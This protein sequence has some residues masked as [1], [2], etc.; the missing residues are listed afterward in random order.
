MWLPATVNPCHYLKITPPLR[1]SPIRKADWVG[2][3]SRKLVPGPERGVGIHYFLSALLLL[4]LLAGFTPEA[5]AQTPPL[6]HI[7]L[8]AVNNSIWEG[9]NAIFTITATPAP[10]AALDVWVNLHQTTGNHA[11]D[12][13]NLGEKTV[14][15][16]PLPAGST[17]TSS[18]VTLTIPTINDNTDEGLTHV[19]MNVRERS[20]H[21]THQPGIQSIV[22]SDNDNPAVSFGASTYRVTEGH[23]VSV[24]LNLV[25]PQ[26]TNT[27]VTLTC[28][29]TATS[30]SDY[31]ACPAPVSIP[32]NMGT[33]TFTLSTT[34]DTLQELAETFTLT[35]SSITPSGIDIGGPS[36][37]TITIDDN[38][39]PV[40][41]LSHGTMPVNPRHGDPA[42]RLE[43]SADTLAVFIVTATPP[44][45]VARDARI[46][47]ESAQDHTPNTGTHTLSFTASG[48]GAGEQRY[49]APVRSDI[50]DRLDGEIRATLLPSEN[51]TYTL[52]ASTIH[53]DIVDNDPTKVTLS[54]T[55]TTADED[56][57]TDTAKINLSLSR[58]LVS[59]ERLDIPLQF[60]GGALGDD[61]TLAKMEGTPADISL[62]GSTVTFTGPSTGA[63]AMSATLIVTAAQDTDTEDETVT[64]SIPARA[65]TNPNDIRLRTTGFHC[66]TTNC[67]ATGTG[68][69][70]FTLSD[71]GSRV[72]VLRITPGSA[73][74]EGANATFTITADPAPAGNLTVYLLVESLGGNQV[75]SSRLGEKTAIIPSSGTLT[76]TI[77]TLADSTDE[78]DSDLFVEILAED[79]DGENPGYT[80]HA[81]DYEAELHIQDDDATTVVLTTPDASATKGSST[82][83]ARIVLTLNRSVDRIEQLDVPLVFT[84]G[85]RV[86]GNPPTGDF[87]LALTPPP[88]SLASS[89]TLSTTSN[90]VSF[91]ALSP[92][93]AT[94]L[95]TAVADSDTIDKTVTVSL[96]AL[97]IVRGFAGGV[98]GS[99]SGDGQITLMDASTTQTPATPE[100]TITP[101]TSP[102]IE[103]TAATFTVTATPP[104]AAALTVNLTITDAP[105][106][107]FVSAS[108]QQGTKTVTIQP[109]STT[110]SSVTYSVPTETD[111]TDEPNGPVMVTIASGSGYTIGS[112][113]SAS[114]TVNDD[115]ATPQT[116]PVDPPQQPVGP[117]PVQPTPTQPVS[118]TSP[119]QPTDPQQP[120]PEPEPEPVIPVLSIQAQADTLTEGATA[121]FT[122]T[123][124]PAPLEPISV[125]LTIAAQGDFT[126]AQSTGVKTLTIDRATTSLMI[127][128]VS[129][130][131]DEADGSIT[132]TLQPADGYTLSPN[133]AATVDIHDDDTA[134]FQLS[135]PGIRIAEIGQSTQYTIQLTSQPAA[136]V[137]ITPITRPDTGTVTPSPTRVTFTRDNWNLAQTFTLTAQQEGAVTLVHVITSQDPNY[138]TLPSRQ[139]PL[140][141]VVGEDLT[142]ITASWQSRFMRTSAGHVVESITQRMQATPTTGLQ[143]QLAGYRMDT[144]PKEMQSHWMQNSRS[145]AE[146]SRAVTLSELLSDSSMSWTTTTDGSIASLWAQGALSEFNGQ[147]GETTLNGEVL[148][149]LIGMDQTHTHGQRGL[150]LSYSQAEGQYQTK[151]QGEIES[152]QTLLTPWMS[153]Q[154]NDRMTLWGALGYGTGDLTLQRSERED[155]TTDTHTAFVAIGSD[156]V[157][158]EETDRTLSIV[159]DALWL[160]TRSDEVAQGMDLGVTSA[161]V[162]TMRAGME[163]RWRPTL[164][165]FA[166]FRGHHLELQAQ[167][168]LRHDGGDAESGFGVEVGGGVQ[169]TN[170][171]QGLNLQINGR[172][173]IT[174]HDSDIKDR[175]LSLSMGFNPSPINQGFTFTLK[176]DWGTVSSGR[177]RLLTAESLEQTESATEQRFKAQ[178]GYGFTI[179]DGRYIAR[180][181]LGV[182]LY[183][184]ERE[185]TLGWRLQS[186]IGRSE[187]TLGLKLTR[188]E[189]DDQSEHRMKVEA[190]VRW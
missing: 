35:I 64:V 44:F 19:Q 60:S 53:Y 57:S 28:T 71:A 55:D 159:T 166:R 135:A 20:T 93:T 81:E 113:G 86:S 161:H 41:T 108:N 16:P 9:A 75:A 107:D 24:T 79:T 138:A 87:T 116:D 119:G 37:T 131:I 167:S 1:G 152:E 177:E 90:V 132:V 88:G 23:S 92:N 70:M 96:G 127:P 169:W 153:R 14:T 154:V 147:S 49:T 74:T 104:P 34:E 11:V 30:G 83:T 56:D 109:A 43:E 122:V 136:A 21:Y 62:S 164:A 187:R 59:G 12:P 68:S 158:Q 112:S 180:P 182:G 65:G 162:S 190:G 8:G 103:G 128:T 47:I 18:S 66:R 77:P 98:T 126:A 69:G 51:N 48:D 72:P 163:G 97:N 25:R 171:R 137:T 26:S 73:I 139:A 188:H 173:L 117:T 80:L 134:G 78:P 185:T 148:T 52:G 67:K 85:S 130:F 40:L 156:S 120:E 110:S 82:D 149:T 32:A 146:A 5:T 63:T 4:P 102:V 42:H 31:A 142:A 175:G 2:G 123:A 150:V 7:T 170:P 45:T 106:S 22:V 118:P 133:P 33:H 58:G 105:N 46:R 179:G 186:V 178:A 155:L 36:S 124:E 183:A 165:R 140:R 174:H 115:D 17:D 50:T 89:Q 151:N 39:Q 10:T 157:L 121:S 76:Y 91:R 111:T 144:T 3:F 101:G 54:V 38:D 13:V 181:H 100:I 160:R 95:L 99:R 168:A 27:V 189:N 61:F 184:Q 145:V 141:V 29:G 114:V 15:I 172:S 125:S 129:D 176:Q 143:G 6:P 94:I 84:G